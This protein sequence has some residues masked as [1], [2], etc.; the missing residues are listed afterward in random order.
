MLWAIEGF[1][2]AVDDADVVADVVVGETVNSVVTGQVVD[3]VLSENIVSGI[4]IRPAIASAAP[5]I[6]T[7]TPAADALTTALSIAVALIALLI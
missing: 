5:E 3:G 1:G 6:I 7:V 4:I 2:E